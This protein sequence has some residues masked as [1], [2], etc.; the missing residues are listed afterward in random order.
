M[1]EPDLAAGLVADLIADLVGIVGAEHVLTTPDLMAAYLT[2]WT[3]QCRGDAI[4]VVRPRS[5]H[6]VVDILQMCYV[7]GISVVPQGGNTG[8]VGGSVPAA[9]SN[10]VVISLTRL[11]DIGAVDPVTG[12][13]TC[14]AGTLLVELQRHAHTA[15]WEFGVDLAARDS[16]TIGGMV[17]TNAGGIHVIHHG[18]MRKQVL[19]LEVV[20]ANGEVVRSMSGLA[21]DNTGYDL[22]QLFCGSEGTLG[23]I[24]EVSLQLVRPQPTELLV[25]GVDSVAEALR[26]ASSFHGSVAAAELI[27]RVSIDS[28]N[29]VAGV[30]VPFTTQFH[31]L[32]EV[33]GDLDSDALSKY[34]HLV[35]AADTTDR[36]RLWAL[37]ERVTEA[38]AAEAVGFIH[39]LDL[40]FPLG[41]LEDSYVALLQ[42]LDR[43]SVH[44][45]AI[46]GHLLDG[47]Y[48]LFFETDSENHAI[49]GEVLE[50]VHRY[51]GSIS[52]EH[53]VGRL[54]AEYLHLS[55]SQAE[56]AAMKAIKG[57][58]DPQGLMNPGVIFI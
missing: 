23:V 31:V 32:L 36:E 15:G 41:A 51:G 8:L 25:F 22:S 11:N 50:L 45:V 57:G 40:S 46:F 48:H 6:D 5:V 47:N 44:K 56:I 49:D 37:R 17:A 2:D 16:A 9:G 33:I 26:I 27:D 34:E 53:G 29:R 43:P 4:A 35:V 20:L 18:M 7:A 28:V 54:K 12:T 39:K 55:R 14:G 13:V 52:A 1:S 42:L 3:G 10:S 38:S 19:G 21:K 30:P 24:T 58:L